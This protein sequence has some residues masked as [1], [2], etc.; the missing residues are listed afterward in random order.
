MF[1]SDV[2]LRMKGYYICKECLG[3]GVLPVIK[4]NIDSFKLDI[5]WENCPSCNGTGWDRERYERI[6]RR[7][8]QLAKKNSPSKRK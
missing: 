4:R 7:C 1:I 8:G 3:E 2:V 5:T 6:K